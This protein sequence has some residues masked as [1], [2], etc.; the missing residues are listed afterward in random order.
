MTPTIEELSDFWQDVLWVRCHGNAAQ[1]EETVLN[2]VMDSP[3]TSEGRFAGALVPYIAAAWAR[4]R[5]P[6]E[7]PYRGAER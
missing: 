2:I 5:R 1:A 6:P 7:P 3:Y 4:E